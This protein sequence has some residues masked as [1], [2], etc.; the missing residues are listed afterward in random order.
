MALVVTHILVPIIILDLLRHY[1]F[2][3]KHF[4]RY[5]IV[6]G[7]IAGL[8]PDFDIPLSWIISMF[9]G[10]LVNFH[11]GFTHSLV[12]PILFSIIA[13]GMHLKEDY[14]WS[15]IFL[16]IAFGW[17]SHLALDCFFGGY[18]T[19]L[20]PLMLDTLRYCPQFGITGM[21]ASID[22]IILTFWIVHEELHKN[23]KDY[24]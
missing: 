11:G 21:S 13:L 19:F 15:N 16:V 8:A 12:F 22:A 4:P 5:L 3:K 10:D 6:I 7:G 20:W 1:V 14:K 24:F 18:K 17:F 2:K 9:S 23:I